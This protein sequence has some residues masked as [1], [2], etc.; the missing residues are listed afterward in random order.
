MLNPQPFEGT[1]KT[2]IS[3]TNGSRNRFREGD[4]RF[5]VHLFDPHTLAFA[6]LCAASAVLSLIITSCAVCQIRET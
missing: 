6:R 3:G 2:S 1:P 4:A 5:D